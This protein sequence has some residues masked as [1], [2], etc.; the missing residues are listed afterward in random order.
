[1]DC[2]L[3]FPDNIVYKPHFM[4]ALFHFLEKTI[5]GDG[6]T[7]SRSEVVIVISLLFVISQVMCDV[8]CGVAYH[9]HTIV[10]IFIIKKYLN[11]FFLLLLLSVSTSHVFAFYHIKKNMFPQLSLPCSP[12]FKQIMKE[13]NNAGD[14]SSGGN[15]GTKGHFPSFVG[16]LMN[17]P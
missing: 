9:I 16:S 14:P 4:K 13:R 7:D 10:C 6:G 15:W 5:D 1:M 12:L 8:R 2:W 17:L 11:I 3:Q